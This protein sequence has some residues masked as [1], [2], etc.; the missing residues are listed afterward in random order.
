VVGRLRAMLS[1]KK[2]KKEQSQHEE[3]VRAQV[4]E[5][6]TMGLSAEQMQFFMDLYG[7]TPE[8]V[9]QYQQMYSS[10][11]PPGQHPIPTQQ[12][13]HQYSFQQPPPGGIKPNQMSNPKQKPMQQQQPRAMPMSMYYSTTK[14]G[15]IGSTQG[16]PKMP[17]SMIP[18]LPPGKKQKDDLTKDLDFE[19]EE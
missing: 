1:E 2:S 8:E 18:S 7:L 17:P 11:S 14:P 10:S 15:T 19:D 6:N 16:T 9:S 12:I 3:E 4:L 13:Y 5:A